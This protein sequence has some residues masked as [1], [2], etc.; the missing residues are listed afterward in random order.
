M[1]FAI[2]LTCVGAMACSDGADADLDGSAGIGAAGPGTSDGRGAD[3]SSAGAGA[4]GARTRPPIAA[5]SPRN[6]LDT[7]DPNF[8]LPDRSVLVPD[9][10]A[11]SVEVPTTLDLSEMAAAYLLGIARTLLPEDRYFHVPPGMVD[12]H[13]TP[14]SVFTGGAPNWG[15]SMQ[16]MVMA[17]QMSGF[18]LDDAQGTLT[19]QLLSTRNM[20]D[21]NVNRNLVQRGEGAWNVITGAN[22]E[23]QMTTAVEALIELYK[24]N[25]LPDL[26]QLVQQMIT[27]HTTRAVPDHNDD[28]EPMLHYR[29]P[30]PGV[31]PY[32]PSSIGT[33]GYGDW[34]FH[35]GKTMR[36][37]STWSLTTGDTQALEST[38]LLGAF[39]RNY[40]GGVFWTVPPGYPEGAGRGHF[41][42]HV[43]MFLNGL[44]GMLW[45]AEA[46]RQ[47]DAAD[48][49][50]AELVDFVRTSY[51]FVRDMHGGAAAALGNFGEICATSD[52]L[53]LAVK[54]TEM[55]AGD[56]NEDIDRWT[57]N[58]IAESQI[59]GAITIE[60][61]PDDP[62]RDRIG[63]KVIGLFFED[64]THALAIPDAHNDQG[65][66]TLQLV[67]CG[68][69]NVI[70]GIFDVWQHIVQFKDDVAQV[71]LLLN[72]PTWWLDVTSE[73][74]YR[75]AVHV[76]THQDLGPVRSIELRVPDDVAPD[77]VRVREG[78][79]PVAFEIVRTR[80]VRISNVRA[81]TRY[82]FELPLAF[83]TATFH[84]LR[85][86]TQNWAESS[87]VVDPGTGQDYAFHPDAPENSYVGVFRGNT[88]VAVDHRPSGGI[89]LYQGADRTSLATLGAADAPATPTQTARRF[90]LRP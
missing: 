74:P 1:L 56:F 17:R 69:G 30:T 13:D 80:F 84:Q 89:G 35:V 47:K 39:V 81:S 85:N 36:A 26:G 21:P 78:D 51:F 2:Y 58:Q 15:K 68:L 10:V 9:G 25:P 23:N 38:T 53:R 50:A 79:T 43:H 33:V 82:T 22:P 66:L 73:I 60:A 88:L 32:V 57:R 18:D 29:L 90:R 34:P 4:T 16:A 44:M 46:L 31:S 52:M 49:K 86:Q 27:Y 76:T 70:H 64:A 75:G 19:S 54:M 40:S 83:R 20:I 14:K 72:K 6:S 62:L 87:Y 77:R 55:G 45:E 37:L 48:A 61:H 63:E 12:M 5:K 67:A 8:V 65:D 7:I 24:Q 42:G 41:A 3:P 71:N 11:E 28:G 59:K